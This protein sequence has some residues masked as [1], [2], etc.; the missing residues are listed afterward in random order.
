MAGARAGGEG[1]PSAAGRVKPFVAFFFLSFFSALGFAQNE[2][3]MPAI[4]AIRLGDYV[5]AIDTLRPL[6]SSGDLEAQY[7]LGVALENAPG[8]QRDVT[9]A[10]QWYTKAAE[11][12][13]P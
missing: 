10:A 9:A 2:R 4:G 12:G 1:H 8:A 11:S 3:L 13:H 6:A 7:I 5:Q